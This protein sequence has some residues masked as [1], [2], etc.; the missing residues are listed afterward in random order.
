[1]FSRP[2]SLPADTSALRSI[3]QEAGAALVIIDPY[4]AYLDGAVN[5]FR[6]QD[7]RRAMHPLKALAEET[8]A[9]VVLVRHLTKALGGS[10]LYRGGGSIGIIGAARM[11][12]LIA[13]DPDDDARRVLAVS[14][15]NLASMPSALAYRLVDDDQH[16]CARVQWLGTTDHTATSL[17]ASPR[18]E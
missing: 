14:K 12:W 13:T 15:S 6:D 3:V 11:G 5:S 7:V 4:M 9:A 18:P 17:L 16:Q 1:G 2:P 8:A 10:P